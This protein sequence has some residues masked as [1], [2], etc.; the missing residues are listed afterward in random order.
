MEADLTLASAT[1]LSFLLFC[2]D[3]GDREAAIT[4]VGEGREGNTQDVL[5][6]Q[7]VGVTYT[8]MESTQ[9]GAGYII[10]VGLRQIVKDSAGLNS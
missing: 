9:E 7:T 2:L 10:S 8:Y 3:D 5:K 1:Y 4:D 6:K